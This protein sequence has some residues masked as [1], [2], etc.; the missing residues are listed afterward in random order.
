MNY[1]YKLNSE[2][3][4]EIT[5]RNIFVQ[6]LIDGKLD[7]T[8]SVEEICERWRWPWD[9]RKE[10]ESYVRCKKWLKENHPEFFI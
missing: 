6:E 10:R 7:Q 1:A 9:E 4:M 2:K 3:F 8:W 5:Q